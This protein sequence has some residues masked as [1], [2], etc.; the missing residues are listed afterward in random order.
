MALW[1][2]PS[3]QLK[4]SHNHNVLPLSQ[5]KITFRVILSKIISNLIKFIEKKYT[6]IYDTK[7]V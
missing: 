2:K 4:N 1:L 6:N 5:N 7:L 3:A